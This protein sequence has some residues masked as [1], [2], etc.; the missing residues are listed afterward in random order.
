MTTAYFPKSFYSLLNMENVEKV[1]VRKVTKGVWELL[2]FLV[3]MHGIQ[4]A[5]LNDFF[6]MQKTSLANTN[7]TFDVTSNR[8]SYYD[9]F[10]SI[11]CK[12]VHDLFLD[13]QKAYDSYIRT[14]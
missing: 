11:I 10:C 1:I 9:K 14:V 2:W 12:E 5:L 13:F 3:A 8:Y 7:V 4:G 6:L